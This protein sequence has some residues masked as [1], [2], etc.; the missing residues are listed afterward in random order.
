MK[1]HESML[2]ELVLEARG[3]GSNVECVA[4]KIRLYT[5]AIGP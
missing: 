1:A 2:V 3:S 5:K 4:Y